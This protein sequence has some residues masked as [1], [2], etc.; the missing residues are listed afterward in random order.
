MQWLAHLAATLE[1]PGS[2]P[3]PELDAHL[4]F[5]FELVGVGLGA[6]RGCIPKPIKPI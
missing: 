2:D 6:C 5:W 1:D 4:V 3:H